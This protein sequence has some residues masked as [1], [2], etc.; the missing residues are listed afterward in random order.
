MAE[1]ESDWE[2]ALE[3]ALE[4]DVESELDP[5]EEAEEEE[6]EALRVVLV[7]ALSAIGLRCGQSLAILPFIGVESA[8]RA[9]AL[10]AKLHIQT[11]PSLFLSSGTCVLRSLDRHRV[12]THAM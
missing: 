2:S 1:S 8:G 11:L 10:D 3:F 6:E 7:P 12:N 5:E 4:S 9:S